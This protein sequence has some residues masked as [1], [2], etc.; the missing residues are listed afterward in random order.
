MS[1]DDDHDPY[2]SSLPR[3]PGCLLLAF[4]LSERT[5]KLGFTVGR[6]Q[7][8]RVRPIPAGALD[9]LADGDRGAKARFGLPP[10]APVV[11]CYEAGREGFWLH[12]YLVAQ[13]VT[14][15]VVDSS[16]IEVNRRARRAKTD[17][18]DLARPADACSSGIGAGRAPRLARGAGPECGGGR[19]APPAS[20]AARRCSKSGRG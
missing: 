3:S 9:Q 11:S 4:E 6:G 17:G 19:R 7:R 12:R 18:L 2:H 1:D 5:W 16:S 8:P 13:G 14:N 15:S 10:T 20:L